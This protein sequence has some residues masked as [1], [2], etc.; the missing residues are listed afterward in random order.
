MTL[1]ERDRISRTGSGCR[2]LIFGFWTRKWSDIA[3]LHFLTVAKARPAG[4]RYVLFTYKAIIPRRARDFL[5]SCGIEVV[6]FDLMRLMRE[7]G[8]G[9][10]T[11][12][13]PLTRCWGLVQ[14]LA[15]R[16]RIAPS[17][18]RFGYGQGRA[19][20]PRANFLFGGPPARPAQLSDYARLVISS[21]VPEH[22]LY[23]DLDFAF[24][25]PL[26]WIF[27]H[28]SFVYR[29]ERHRFANNALMSVT[30]DSPIK[31]GL[32]IDFLV[33]FG[34]VRHRVLF[35]DAVCDACGLEVLS[36]DRLDP[37]WSEI[38]PHGPRY[39]GFFNR[40]ES[41]AEELAF[42]R[43]H[44]DAIH[45]HNKWGHTPDPGSPYDLWLRELS[46]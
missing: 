39:R 25:R 7:T 22:T 28:R 15:R 23:V 36:C 40:S 13:T 4:S 44:F 30:A 18:S 3:R 21:I 2:L 32:L 24:P 34:T 41:S 11:R 37:L 46:G 8:A 6:P 16:P 17:L 43:H 10:M 19:F 1:T 35:A 20:A 45:W 26:D 9:I 38:G 31:R 14:W 12:R 5:E 33:R 27:E 42:L 29:W